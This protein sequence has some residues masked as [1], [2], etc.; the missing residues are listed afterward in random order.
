MITIETI[1]EALT[2][3]LATTPSFSQRIKLLLDDHTLIIDGA[4]SPPSL[5]E[6]EGE[7]EVTAAMALEDFDKLIQKKMNAQMALMSGK[8]KIKGDMLAALPLMKLL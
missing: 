7:A 6:G 5:H 3:K 1:T 8:I 4:T 2:T